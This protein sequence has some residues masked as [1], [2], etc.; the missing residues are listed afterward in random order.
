MP[1]IS[2][3]IATYNT[4][5]F[6]ERAIDSVFAQT[7]R[8]FEVIVVDDGSTDRT[9]ELIGARGDLLYLRIPNGGVGGARNLGMRRARGEWI[10]L[11]DADDAWH[12]DKLERQVEV[13]R[14]PRFKDVSVIFSDY[15][16]VRGGRL[17]RA[18]A[19][20]AGFP[21]YTECGFDLPQLLTRRERLGD[22]DVY[23]GVDIEK[24]FHG[25]YIMPSTALLRRA[26]VE[27][28]GAFKTHYRVGC[29][30]TDLFLRWG[31]HTDFACLDRPL[32]DY[33]IGRPGQ[34]T[35]GPKLSRMIRTDIMTRKDFLRHHPEFERAHPE[36]T[37]R[38]FAQV[39]ARLGRLELAR[40]GY[41]QARRA[42]ALA[43]R[44]HPLAGRDAWLRRLACLPGVLLRPLLEMTRRMRRVARRN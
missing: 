12:P 9:P 28:Y 6:I 16:E 31:Y 7:F 5:D 26:D 41:P 30:D 40:G 14:D 37:A 19:M 23:H 22:V 34:Q 20:R 2:V 29:E 42:L 13:A 4:A 1:T 18:R 38:V 11:L 35:A 39:Y 10:A 27:R 17:I 33:T 8:D 32:A 21:I 44:H 15:N 36:L 24:L 43:Q 25:N 3:V